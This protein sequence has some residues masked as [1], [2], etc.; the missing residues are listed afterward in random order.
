M[1]L[2]I[3]ALVFVAVSGFCLALASLGNLILR[4]VRLEMATDQEQLL[5]A[6][7]VGLVVIEIALF[8]V[9]ATQ[10][11]R[12][13]CY[14]VL[15]FLCIPFSVECRTVLKTAF[16]L[17]KK[18]VPQSKTCRYLLLLLSFIIL[19]EFLTAVAPLTGSDALHYHFTTQA[20]ILEQ[21]FRPIFCI[22]HSF[23][24]G[25]SHL[26]IL[27]GLALGSEKLA[28]GSIFLGGILT[29]LS[30]ACLASRWASCLTTSAITVLFLLTPVVFWQI[31]SSGSPDI[32]MGFLTCTT[33]L[34][35]RQTGHAG[36]RKLA[37]LA[38][39]LAGGVAGAKYTGCIMTASLAVATVFEFRSGV[40]TSFFVAGS[41]V[42]GVWPYLRNFA[43]TGDPV[44]PFYSRLLSPSLV[45][46]YA[47]VSLLADTGASRSR[48]FG[49][50][51]PFL[52]FAGLQPNNIGFWDFFGPIIFALGPLM[53]L[54]FK[55]AKDLRLPATVWLVFAFVVFFASSLPRLGLPAFPLALSCAAAGISL[56]QTKNWAMTGKLALGSIALMS[57][58]GGLAFIIYSREPLRTTLGMKDEA[59]YL[60]QWAPDYQIA[61]AVNRLLANRALDG[62]ALVFFRH[63]YYLRIPFVNGDPN[64]SWSANPNILRTRQQWKAFLAQERIRYVVK[65]PNYPSA[66]AEA[67]EGMEKN[68][69]LV[70]FAET[71]V[72]N[73]SGMRIKGDRMATHVVIFRVSDSLP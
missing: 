62:N 51:L 71:V 19:V 35:L 9:Q 63:L 12:Q 34:V 42:S 21:G 7:A 24:C 61:E 4:H 58:I 11:V 10:H 43:W 53:V 40:W 60:E 65:S 66:I 36:T 68:G 37:L 29:A 16:K 57:I 47:L 49:E 1:A 50:L 59:K 14:A 45:N 72:Q 41:F 52:F 17:I 18:L 67:L 70:P 23:L 39:L 44:F 69:D 25:Q 22:S 48:D 26:L 2:A 13:G 56:A 30:L 38:G 46:E 27:F 15:I 5:V 73:I 8:A 31:S 28:L 32:W 20:L 3:A 33:V 6:V 54:A 64:S 55:N